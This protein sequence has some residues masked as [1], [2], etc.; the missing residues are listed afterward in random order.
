[1]VVCGE[2]QEVS[3]AVSVIQHED[4]AAL[5]APWGCNTVRRANVGAYEAPSVACPIGHDIDAKSGRLSIFSC[6]KR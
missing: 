5:R 6:C 1:M 2:I 3:P 4:D